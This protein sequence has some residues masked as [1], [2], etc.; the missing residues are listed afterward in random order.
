MALAPLGFVV[1][2]IVLLGLVLVGAA[3][4]WVWR[5]DPMHPAFDVDD[6][7]RPLR[8]LAQERTRLMSAAL[9]GAIAGVGAIILAIRTT[10]WGL[11][12]LAGGIGA[13]ATLLA[14][15]LMP[16]PEREG[17]RGVAVGAR[18][19][20]L[21]VVAVGVLAVALAIGS[22]L[23]ATPS[24]YGGWGLPY[25]QVTGISQL[26]PDGPLILD[27]TATQLRP[28]LGWPDAVAASLIVV[29]I[30]VLLLLALRRLARDNPGGDATFAQDVYRQRARIVTGV[31]TGGLLVQVGIIGF[32]LG[33]PLASL[34]EPAPVVTRDAWMDTVAL[35][36]HATVGAVLAVIGAGALVLAV[37][38]LV[39][40]TMTLT[41]LGESGRRV[42]RPGPWTTEPLR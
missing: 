31:V 33:A 1:G 10:S 40:A 18:P 37:V 7:V 27:R 30:V 29:A 3:V 24:P 39:L 38:H 13:V 15:L 42:H 2:G 41:R 25:D 21:P 28:W 23:V 34:S 14:A 12:F 5:G 36:P 26:D 16:T 17:P 19:R 20:V 22:A 4:A 32:G 11:L 35:Q 8:W 6:P 9:L